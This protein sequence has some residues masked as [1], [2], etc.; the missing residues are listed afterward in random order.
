MWPRCRGSAA[1]G[2]R[3]GAASGGRDRTASGGHGG[4]GSTTVATDCRRT[5]IPR[6]HRYLSVLRNSL[7]I[8]FCAASFLAHEVFVL[9]PE[10]ELLLT[11]C[12]KKTLNSDILIGE[13]LIGGASNPDP[14]AF[15]SNQF[16]VCY[17]SSCSSQISTLVFSFCGGCRLE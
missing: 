3:G 6:R 11:M 9:M 2:G 1:G 12:S 8:S 14:N 10:W 17:T 15:S 4:V 16:H 13:E 5:S 7:W